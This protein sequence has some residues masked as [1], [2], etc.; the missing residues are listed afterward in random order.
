M[1]IRVW[2]HPTLLIVYSIINYFLSIHIDAWSQFNMCVLL[3]YMNKRLCVHIFLHKLIIL[4]YRN[5][6]YIYCVHIV[7]YIHIVHIY[8]SIWIFIYLF[9]FHIVHRNVTC[10]IWWSDFDIRNQFVWSRSSSISWCSFI[11]YFNTSTR[12]NIIII[13]SLC[14]CDVMSVCVCVCVC[15]RARDTHTFIQYVISDEWS[16]VHWVPIAPWFK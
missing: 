12:S 10:M 14:V 4:N 16:N 7:Q 13:I 9:M 5:V 3:L 11:C 8:L 6:K 1:V 15:S 2:Y